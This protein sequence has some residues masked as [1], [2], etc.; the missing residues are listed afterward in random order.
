VKFAF[1]FTF[2]PPL[3]SR[4]LFFLAPPI[5]TDSELIWKF[6]KIDDTHLVAKFRIAGYLNAQQDKLYFE[7]GK[8]A[9]TLQDYTLE[10][11]KVGD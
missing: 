4:Y 9:V 3:L 1:V 7:A 6:H 2:V 5:T 8:K 10:M 11:T